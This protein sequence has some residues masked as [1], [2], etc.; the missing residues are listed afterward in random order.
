MVWRDSLGLVRQ[1]PIVG[2]GPEMFATEFPAFQSVKLARAYPDFYHESPHNLCLDALISQGV[3]GLALLILVFVQS[4]IA[5]G[6]WVEYKQLGTALLAALSASFVSQQ[7]T[8]FIVPTAFVF[9]FAAGMLVAGAMPENTPVKPLNRRVGR[10]LQA[11]AV[12]AGTLFL[13]LAVQ[14][15]HVDFRWG[16]VRRALEA[17]RI[18][19]AMEEYRAVTT[20]V[21]PE[22]GLD[23]WYSRELITKTASSTETL[24]QLAN[25][26]ALEAAERATTVT[27]DRH[28]AYY[29]LAVLDG[30][31]GDLPGAEQA[32]HSSIASAPRWFKPHWLLS[33]IL[34]LTG[35]L[36]E[37]ESEAQLAVDLNGGKNPEVAETLEQIQA[38]IRRR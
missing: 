35:N 12:P 34:N 38:A 14:L 23:M 13:V 16:L 6:R 19:E 36:N 30:A 22:T 10:F 25:R 21:P 2:V 7:F 28:N 31:Q 1:H 18:P 5:A 15:V 8:A 4:W 11:L 17:N 33:E 20:M 26:Q 9:H 24:K 37:A 29:N 27:E 3:P 32:L